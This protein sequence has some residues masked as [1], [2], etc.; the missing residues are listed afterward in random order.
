MEELC[1][2][3]KHTRSGKLE[4]IVKSVNQ[5]LIGWLGYYRLATTPSVFKEMD[6]WIRRRLRQM[7]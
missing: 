5:Y 1:H 2:L 7:V 4:D 6:E 3:I